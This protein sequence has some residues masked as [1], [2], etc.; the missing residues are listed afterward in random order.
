MRSTGDFEILVVLAGFDCVYHFKQRRKVL[1]FL[2]GFV[3]DVADK[4]AV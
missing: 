3:P 2:R 4:G 1:F